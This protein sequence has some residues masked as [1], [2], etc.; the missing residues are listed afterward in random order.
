LLAVPSPVFT[1]IP[2]IAPF[3][4]TVPVI[5]STSIE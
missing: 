1:T 2:F 3:F 4:T 5:F